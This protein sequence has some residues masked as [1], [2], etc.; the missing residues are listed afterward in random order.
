[1]KI[2]LI[3]LASYFY[4]LRFAT[5]IQ[6]LILDLSVEENVNDTDQIISFSGTTPVK[7]AG[8]YMAYTY[9]ATPPFNVKNVVHRGS[10]L[11]LNG[12]H[13][14]VSF[15]QNITLYLKGDFPLLLY[16]LQPGIIYGTFIYYKNVGNGN[17]AHVNV[18]SYSK[19]G[20]NTLNKTELNA[21][22]DE[23]AENLNI[24]EMEPKAS[25]KDWA[26]T[27]HSLSA[28]VV[29]FLFLLCRL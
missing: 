28:I 1:M 21:L 4:L 15:V 18:S 13:L 8:G 19:N 9:F 5:S 20:T 7:I 24:S 12:K 23:I 17:W 22:L 16:F 25:E 26:E 10:A 3:S 29:L 14:T 2:T 27:T 11:L 6:G